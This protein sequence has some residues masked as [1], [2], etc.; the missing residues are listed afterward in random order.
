MYAAGLSGSAAG[1]D[2]RRK[3]PFEEGDLTRASLDD[4]TRFR[5]DHAGSGTC[6]VGHTDL[7]ALP[8]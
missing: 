4:W 5:L 1:R 2:S 3:G 7:L 6:V 8:V